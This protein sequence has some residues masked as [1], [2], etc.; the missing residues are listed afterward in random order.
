MSASASPAR[1]VPFSRAFPDAL[2]CRRREPFPG[3]PPRAAHNRI[4]YSSQIPHFAISRYRSAPITASVIARSGW[5]SKPLWTVAVIGDNARSVARRAAPLILSALINNT[6][7]AAF[8]ADFFTH[9]CR[10]C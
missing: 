5:Y 9:L 4:S 1:F 7:S 6:F 10:A 2:E 8:R 3:T